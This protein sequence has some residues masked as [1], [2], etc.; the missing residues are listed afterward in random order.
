M[1]A[2]LK[3]SYCAWERLQHFP[4]KYSSFVLCVLFW[5]TCI[6]GLAG[7]RKFMPKNLWWCVVGRSW[8]EV[9]TQ[10]AVFLK[11]S[12]RKESSFSNSQNFIKMIFFL[13]DVTHWQA[14][15][16]PSF[17]SEALPITYVVIELADILYNSFTV[18]FLLPKFLSH[19]L[20]TGSNAD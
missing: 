16:G 6:A 11:S 13:T 20:R 8:A 9:L 7:Y 17:M 4:W 18:V 10:H 5:L 1:I 19:R 12:A 2:S 14:L 3:I 15:A